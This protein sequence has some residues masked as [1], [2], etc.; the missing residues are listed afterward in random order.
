MSLSSLSTAQNWGEVIAM[1]F[2]RKYCLSSGVKLA[3]A[4]TS[5]RFK[6]IK[7]T[8]SDRSTQFRFDLCD[9]VLGHGCGNNGIF[10]VFSV[11]PENPQTHI[12]SEMSFSERWLTF[13]ENRHIYSMLPNR[14]GGTFSQIAWCKSS[15]S[16]FH[17]RPQ[18]IN[19]Y[20]LI[21]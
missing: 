16:H 20:T 15:W 17:Q 4:G 2:E 14:I 7:P 6:S 3:C 12:C 21:L 18:W 9:C 5:W 13:T 1:V 19:P 8:I 10:L 11:A